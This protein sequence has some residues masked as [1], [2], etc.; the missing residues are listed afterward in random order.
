MKTQLPKFILFVL[1]NSLGLHQ[2]EA[3]S[4]PEIQDYPQ[5]HQILRGESF[6]YFA[7]LL[8]KH[9]LAPELNCEIRGRRVWS[10]RKFSVG[11]RRVE[12]IEIEYR[13][14]GFLSSEKVTLAIPEGVKFG[15]RRVPNAL[16]GVVEEYRVELR[17]S[18][19]HWISVKHDGRYNLVWFEIGNKL[20]HLP[21]YF[22]SK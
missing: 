20:R 22:R 18:D 10:E 4:F 11:V 14:G 16:A 3:Q 21:C 7:D 9:R 8:T 19:S 12:V 1:I 5:P 17:D 13:P 15:T 2:A 6:D